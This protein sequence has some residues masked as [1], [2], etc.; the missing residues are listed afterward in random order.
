VFAEARN[1]FIP[2]FVRVIVVE[3]CEL[4]CLDRDAAEAVRGSLDVDRAARLA[5][6]LKAFSDPTRLLIIQALALREAVW[7]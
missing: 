7:L 1:P 4:L 3:T 6:T 5:S 2:R